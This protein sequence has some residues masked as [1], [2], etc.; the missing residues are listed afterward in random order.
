MKKLPENLI[1]FWKDSENSDT[2]FERHLKGIPEMW[3]IDR[4]L[5][6][7]SIHEYF[8]KKLEG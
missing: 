7:F 2:V 4:T 8:S 1:K 3:T 5:K 6:K